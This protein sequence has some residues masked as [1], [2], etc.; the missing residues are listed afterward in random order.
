MPAVITCVA[1]TH[2]ARRRGLAG[3]LID[4]VV[5]D[6]GGRGFSA[7]EAYPDLTLAPDEASAAAPAFWKT[8][9]FEL[10]AADE[11]FPVMRREL[12]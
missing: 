4:D 12:A 1:A 9:G 7:I 10:A 2:E 3:H 8:C 5:R 11:R 6:L